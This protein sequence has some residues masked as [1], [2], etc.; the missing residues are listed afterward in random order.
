LAELVKPAINDIAANLLFDN[1]PFIEQRHNGFVNYRFVDDI[2]V[3]QAAKGGERVL[4][5]FE[6]RRS[7]NPR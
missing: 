6:Q 7:G 3:K 4:F 1:A 2:L 5:L